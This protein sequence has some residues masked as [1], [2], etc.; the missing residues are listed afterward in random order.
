MS[1]GVYR[2]NRYNAVDPETGNLINLIKYSN[3]VYR[4]IAYR[5]KL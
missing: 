5:R 4:I 2:L 1:G 3:K